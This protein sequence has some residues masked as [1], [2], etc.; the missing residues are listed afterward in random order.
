MLAYIIQQ[1]VS[2]DF[3]YFTF[4]VKNYFRIVIYFHCYFNNLLLPLLIFL[5]MCFLFLTCDNL[6]RVI[7][8]VL[9]NSL[10]YSFI[11][12]FITFIFFHCMRMGM[13]Q[14]PHKY[15]IW[16]VLCNC[17]SNF[18]LYFTSLIFF[19]FVGFNQGIW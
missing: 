8:I 2:I 10:I 3:L 11:H 5:S 1:L 17:F 14:L 18:F 12:L 7:S 13:K 6:K 16:K 19:F 4:Y 15:F 9:S